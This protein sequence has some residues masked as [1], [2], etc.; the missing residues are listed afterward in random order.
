MR[1]KGV[2]SRNNIAAPRTAPLRPELA[3]DVVERT[4]RA[5]IASVITITRAFPFRAENSRAT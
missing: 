2:R 1:S 5:A 3:A 4:V